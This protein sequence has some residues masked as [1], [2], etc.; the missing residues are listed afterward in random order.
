MTKKAI[1]EDYLNHKIPLYRTDK[2][3]AP[4]RQQAVYKNQGDW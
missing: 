1:V 2:T 4:R 3:K